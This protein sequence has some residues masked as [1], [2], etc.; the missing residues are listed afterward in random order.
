MQ[1]RSLVK[2][3]GNAVRLTEVMQVLVKHG[4]ADLVQ[5]AR[6]PEGITGQVLRGLHIIE[7]E[8]DRPETLG[9]RLRAALTELGPTF[10]KFGQILS[11]RP[12]LIG[13]DLCLELSQLQDRVKTL[14]FDEMRPVIEGDLRTTV[15]LAFLE[16]NPE[17]IAAA[18]LSQ[19]Y[20]ARLKDGTPVAV[21]VQRPGARKV[22]ES[23]LQFMLGIAEWIANHVN[24]LDW[25]DPVGTVTEFQRSILRELDFSV[26]AR[27]IER[28]RRDFKDFPAVFVPKTYIDCCG[29]RVLTM[30]WI[31]G[32]RVDKLDE[33][34]ARNCDPRVVAQIG[35]DVLC[36]QVFEHNF[37]HAD[38]HPG[39]ILVTRNNQIAFLDYGMVGHLERIDVFA[40]ADLL[41]FIFQQDSEGCVRTLLM[42]TTSDGLED[43]TVLRHE[44]A[45]YLAFEA[46]AIVAH[47]Q[48]GKAIERVTGILR[49]H[50]LQLAPR[51]SLLLKALATIESTGHSLDP[52]LDMVPIIRPHV[53]RIVKNRY[54]PQRIATDAQQ[55]LL[56]LIRL[57]RQW[58]HDI[59]FIL[60]MLRRGKLKVQLNHEGLD[61]FA[62]VTDRASNRITFG[63]IAG[64]L[65]VG[66]SFLISSDVG[67]RTLGLV[68]YSIAAVL[69]V[70]VLISIL[71]SKNY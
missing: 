4:F 10:V 67:S 14:P 26:E 55:H 29:S 36:R 5:R 69:G 31:D 52:S 19:V 53:E 58:P 46:E 21:K 16:F 39:N 54:S 43:T 70:A 24:E 44:V 71:R 22:I 45:D 68:G 47:G 1:Y 63:L 17:P 18:S 30:D 48:L 2:K 28:F 13:Q 38:P 49:R 15:E 59:Q 42:F 6:L 50:H 33:Y 61:H 40:M 9:M 64:A 3:V 65:I 62:N 66:S 20:R 8:Q 51:F 25:I 37:Y 34:P 57:G 23:D 35:C 11:T 41:R 32:V 56:S 7:G 12:D 27:V 60:S